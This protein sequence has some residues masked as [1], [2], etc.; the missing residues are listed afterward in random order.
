LT[1]VTLHLHRYVP[2][3]SPAKCASVSLHQAEDDA[4][5]PDA[6]QLFRDE[7]RVQDDAPPGS[8]SKAPYLHGSGHTA[9]EVIEKRNRPVAALLNK[10]GVL[11]YPLPSMRPPLPRVAKAAQML[12]KFG[13]EPTT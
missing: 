10:L 11:T 1:R 3:R 4:L 6:A 5:H 8:T 12:T 9:A 2:S 13:T 7:N